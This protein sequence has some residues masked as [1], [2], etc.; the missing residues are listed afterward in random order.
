MFS[1]LLRDG[2]VSELPGIISGTLED[3]CLECR[4]ANGAV[5]RRFE[6]VKVLAYGI[7]DAFALLDDKARLAGSRLRNPD[8]SFC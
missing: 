1:V 3:G 6:S 2:T 7:S 5:I 4:D 8:L